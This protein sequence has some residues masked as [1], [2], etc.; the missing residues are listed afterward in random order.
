MRIAVLID[1]P[2]EARYHRATLAALEHAAF[3]LGLAMDLRVRGTAEVDSEDVLCDADGVVI[4]PGSPYRDE[5][6][7]WSIIRGARQRGVPLVGT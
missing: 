2:S 5:P 3:A 7:V 1:L 6:T 4:G